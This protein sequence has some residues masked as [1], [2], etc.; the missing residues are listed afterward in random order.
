M[1]YETL[2]ECHFVDM[3]FKKTVNFKTFCSVSVS[4]DSQCRN[5]LGTKLL[6][7][8]SKPPLQGLPFQLQDH[9]SVCEA[10]VYH[11]LAV[12]KAHVTGRGT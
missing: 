11:L 3:V 7:Y 5:N 2:V 12:K 1:D 4:F 6:D 8:K 9:F 10:K